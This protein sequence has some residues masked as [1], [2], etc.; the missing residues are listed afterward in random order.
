M[1][2]RPVRP[3]KY[4]VFAAAI[5]EVDVGLVVKEDAINVVIVERMGHVCK[6]AIIYGAHQR[7]ALL[8]SYMA[9]VIADTSH[10]KYLHAAK[11]RI[12]P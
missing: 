8:R 3:K 1:D 10:L 6:R 2:A 5:I 11:I 7:M 4:V 9:A 12:I